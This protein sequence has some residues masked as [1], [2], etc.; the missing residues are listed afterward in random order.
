MLYLLHILIILFLPIVLVGLTN[1]TKA[2]WAGRKG[3]PILQLGYDINRLMRK[4]SVY[5]TST[6]WIFQSSGI[7]FLGST[8]VA[9]CLS[10]VIPGFS[11]ISFQYDFIFFAYILALGRIFLILGALDTASA[12]EG[13]GA[14]REAA[15]SAL[16][17]PALFISLG[18][19]SFL[20]N[21]SSLNS[22]F[23]HGPDFT[24]NLAVIILCA[25]S[26]FILLQTESSHVPVD[27]PNT[28][29]ELT[30]IHEV[31]ILDHSGGDLALIQYAS[32]MKMTVLAG[33]IA[34]LF[35]PFSI[36]TD[37]PLAVVTSLFIMAGVAIAVGLFESCIARVR[38]KTVPFYLS[39]ALS[40]SLLALALA[41]LT[42]WH[43]Q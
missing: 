14:S 7:V 37:L 3:Y 15:Y 32:A 30:M 21:S 26:L 39:F 16:I 35:N 42:K 31:M 33:L 43:I 13:M 28:H 20:S 22:V 12:F 29:L 34:C 11:L 25:I 8:I 9:A 19:L 10:P 6:S 4:S 18:T 5:S 27:D 23:I 2:I 24:D 1:R 38:L 17:E 41:S 36:S 40:S